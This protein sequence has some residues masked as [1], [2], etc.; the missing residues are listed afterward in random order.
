MFL[1]RVLSAELA[2]VK[3]L[4]L[5]HFGIEEFIDGLFGRR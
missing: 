3:G 1:E 5:L 4:E 2:F